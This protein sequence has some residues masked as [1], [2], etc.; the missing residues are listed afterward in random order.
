MSDLDPFS[1][2]CREDPYPVYR[3]LR[4]DAPVHYVK[5]MDAWC[6]SRYDDVQNVLKN[7][8][9]FSSRAMFTM[10]MNNGSNGLDLSWGSLRLAGRLLFNLRTS[11]WAFVRSRILI[12]SDGDRHSRWEIEESGYTAGNTDDECDGNR[13]GDHYNCRASEIFMVI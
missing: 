1:S 8:E 3:A 6:V 4:D 7:P 5:S 13:D 12:A 10:L 2:A 9:H 11:P